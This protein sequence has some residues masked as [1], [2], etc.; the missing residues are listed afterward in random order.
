[1]RELQTQESLKGDTCVDPDY[2]LFLVSTCHPN[3]GLAVSYDN[4]DGTLAVLCGQCGQEIATFLIA[5]SLLQ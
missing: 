3:V 2:R 5:P 1:M 4:G